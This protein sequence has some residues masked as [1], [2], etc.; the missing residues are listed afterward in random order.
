MDFE[1]EQRL[2]KLEDWTLDTLVRCRQEIEKLESENKSL[3][4]ENFYLKEKLSETKD[5]TI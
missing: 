5:L 3:K 4:E 2:H 1:L